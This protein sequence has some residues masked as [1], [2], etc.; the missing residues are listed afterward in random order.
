MGLGFL[1]AALGLAT[2]S[3]GASAAGAFGARP[4][5]GAA[6]SED[7]PVSDWSLAPLLPSIAAPGDSGVAPA[8]TSSFG[9]SGVLVLLDASLFRPRMSSVVAAATSRAGITTLSSAGAGS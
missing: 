2:G 8:G 3:V 4:S 5:S 9:S 7:G 6:T 1:G